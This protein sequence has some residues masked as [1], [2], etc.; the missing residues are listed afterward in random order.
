M[1][2][3]GTATDAIGFVGA[4]IIAAAYFLNQRGR[5]ASSDW[6]FPATNL[7]GSLLIMLSLVVHPNLPSVVIEVFWSAI[8]LY[9]L[10][11][12][13]RATLEHRSN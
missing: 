10:R 9:G 4:A 5:L 2:W 1:S 11:R 12:N 6:R 7:G 13:R 8:S 3:L